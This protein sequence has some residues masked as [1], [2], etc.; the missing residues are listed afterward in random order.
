VLFVSLE[1]L[2]ILLRFRSVTS[3]C[4]NRPLNQSEENSFYS[5]GVFFCLTERIYGLTLC[6][7]GRRSF[8]HSVL[9]ITWSWYY[10]KV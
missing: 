3:Q 2:G 7:E 9:D 6:C 4:Q 8:Y 1:S 5:R 10:E